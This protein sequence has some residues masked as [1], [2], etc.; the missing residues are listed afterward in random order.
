[1]GLL[2]RFE[3]KVPSTAE[4]LVAIETA[5]RIGSEELVTKEVESGV[6]SPSQSN[7]H[8]VHPEWNG[9]F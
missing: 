5:V 6:E 8:H 2:S 3:K 9:G 4:D 7:E 1:M